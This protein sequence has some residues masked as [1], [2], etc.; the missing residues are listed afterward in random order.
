MTSRERLLCAMRLGDPGE[1]PIHICG[2]PVWDDAW[3]QSRDRSYA[4]VIEAVQEYGDYFA[5]WAPPSGPFLS[6]TTVPT[7]AEQID[8]PDWVET[9][10]TWHT[11]R[12]D[13]RTRHLSSKRGLPGYQVEFAVKSLGDVEKV[14]SV[15]YVPLEHVDASGF[16]ALQERV[17][18]R[19]VVNASAGQNPIGDVRDLMGS[20]L[21]AVWSIEQ[22]GAIHRLLQMFLERILD[23]LEAILAAGVG[24]IFT[25]LGQEYITPPLHGR[26]D[27]IEFCVEPEKAIIDRIHRAGGLLHVHCHGTLGA[28]LDDIARIAD[29]L[30][31]IEPPPMGDVPLPEA[32]R[33]IGDR[34]C[35][36][37][38]IQTGDIY[39]MPTPRLLD[40][41]KRAIDDGAPGGG[42]ILCPTASP[43]T[44][45]LTDLTVRNYVA[46]I[47]TAAEYGRG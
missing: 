15:P 45:V 10:T 18:D 36:D 30:H 39:A 14:L 29:I 21:L 32:K 33:R 7:E 1:L 24:P 23:R 35:L 6:Q 22:R 28:I 2:V 43:Y 16:F 9:I 13:L 11:P 12:G 38:N 26:R 25:T 42:F 47:Q 19:G 3:V 31:P 46:M 17:G 8:H 37:G 41:V 4:P 40:A 20:D 5:S 27:F 44:Q 34:V